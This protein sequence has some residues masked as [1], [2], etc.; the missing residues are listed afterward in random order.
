[1]TTAH[2]LRKAIVIGGGIAGTVAAIA[3]RKA[4]LDA[5]IHEAYERGADG[6]GAFLTLAANGFRGLRVLGLDGPALARGF[7]TPR[8]SIELGNGDVLTQ[9]PTGPS[10]GDDITRT[11]ARADLYGALRDE[12]VARGVPVFYGHRLRG[13]EPTSSGG[14][15]A[16]F[17]D[18]SEVEGD[19]LV[20]AD[21]LHS[22][23]R[24]LLDPAAPQPRYLGLLNTGG[25]ARGLSLGGEPG[26]M[27]MIFGKRCFY[28]WVAHPD[29]G[30]I[31]WFANPARAREPTRRE[32]ADIAPEAWRAELLDL[33]S[34][35]RTPGAAIAAATEQVFAGWG[36]H[37]LPTV[38]VWHRDR[39]LIIGDAAHA[40]APSS[41]QGASMAIE[42]AVVLAKC[43]RDV[44]DIDAAFT[45]YERHRRAR[46][47]RVVAQGKRN[48]DG[49]TPGPVGR[50]VRDL[51]L[52]LVFRRMSSDPMAWVHG[53]S[54]D[55]AEPVE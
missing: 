27:H 55:W 20:G 9:I 24:T 17:D 16:Q 49:K 6:I 21:G 34:V 50:V 19:L 45:L 35:D 14:V 13:V 25:Y 43:L 26:T 11:V 44:R 30:S 48:G 4:G 39:M 42:D 38:P 8:F 1:M 32:L 23:L 10:G 52:R 2:R 40:A 41:G 28:A 36:T 33:L 37:D 22:R 53:L 51:I 15:A 29:D 47:E 31:W 18:G 12:A 46:V 7:D 5:E 3:L 54:L